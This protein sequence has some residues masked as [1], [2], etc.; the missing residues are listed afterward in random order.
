MKKKH[1]HYL[2]VL[3]VVRFDIFRDAAGGTQ[4]FA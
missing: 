3:K 4:Y 1:G 2:D